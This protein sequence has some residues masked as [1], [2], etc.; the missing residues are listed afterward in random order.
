M[1]RT[2]RSSLVFFFVLAGIGGA[3]AQSASNQPKARK[4]RYA[5]LCRRYRHSPLALCR[6]SKSTDLLPEN[7]V[8]S[9]DQFPG[10]KITLVE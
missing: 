10:I 3:A 5:Q 4:Q 8:P 2:I 7:C 6:E 9:K 1:R